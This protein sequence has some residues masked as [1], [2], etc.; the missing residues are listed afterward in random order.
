M[1]AVFSSPINFLDTAAN[2]ADGESERRIGA[3][4]REMRGLPKDYVLATKADRDMKSGDF[5]G[6]QMKRSIENSLE[7]LGVESFQV[8]Y[9]HDPEH[10]S[11]DYI[12]ADGG[13]LD[14]LRDFVDQGVIRHLGIAGGPIDLMIEYVETGAF[15]AVIPHNRYTLLYPHRGPAVSNGLGTRPGRRQRRAVRQR[16]PR[17]RPRRVPPLHVRYGWI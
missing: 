5:S 12:T 16:N 11:F 10:S 17:Q 2:Y 15:E 6:D 14:T 1:R 4:L 8:L 13:A 7:N 9:L 3:V